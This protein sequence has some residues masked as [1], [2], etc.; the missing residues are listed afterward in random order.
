MQEM[1]YQVRW[2]QDSDHGLVHTMNFRAKSPEEAVN[3]A[4][5]FAGNCFH[6]FVDVKEI[7]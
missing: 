5:R 3:K 2:R 6:T 7:K 1:N 4:K